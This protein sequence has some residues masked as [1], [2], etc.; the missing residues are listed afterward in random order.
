MI[1]STELILRP[2]DANAEVELSAQDLLALSDFS[3]LS[4]AET[5]PRSPPS[6]PEVIPLRREIGATRASSA[7]F[8]KAWHLPLSLFVTIGIV[9]AAYM[10][11]ASND[12][13]QPTADSLEHTSQVPW[14]VP[15]QKAEGEPVL[16]ANPF[17]TE[18]VFE[19]PPGTSESEAREAV[20]ELLMERARA[21]QQT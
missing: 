17:D 20:A 4:E 1:K 3:P 15:E 12:T 21:R 18:E 7:R 11:V 10:F 9:G 2:D 14:P 8:V 19:F 5:N 6:R 13:S 16:F